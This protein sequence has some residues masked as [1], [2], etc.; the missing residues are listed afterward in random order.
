MFRN[1][2]TVVTVCYYCVFFM[3][4]TEIKE[5]KILFFAFVIPNY[6]KL[7]LFSVLRLISAAPVSTERRLSLPI[8]LLSLR[9]ILKF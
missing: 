4:T 3:T 9:K 1:E 5:E 6:Q 8:Y 7:K 2:S